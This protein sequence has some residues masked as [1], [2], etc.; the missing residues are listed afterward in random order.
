MK[1]KAQSISTDQ[2]FKEMISILVKQRDQLT[3]EISSAK[4]EFPNLVNAYRILTLYAEFLERRTWAQSDDLWPEL[5]PPH[6]EG[7]PIPDKI[8]ELQKI[9]GEEQ[10][11]N[12]YIGHVKKTQKCGGITARLQDI[13]EKIA[14]LESITQLTTSEFQDLDRLRMQENT[15][16]EM[17]VENGCPIPIHPDLLGPRVF[18][19]P[20]V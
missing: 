19:L 5:C 20:I 16:M 2:F 14:K 15:V 6:P 8:Q 12:E 3:K 17:L 9:I 1:S 10:R 7:K 11:W 18:E 4:K 13:W